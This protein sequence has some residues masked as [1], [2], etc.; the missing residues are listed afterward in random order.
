MAVIYISEADVVRNPTALFE[1]VRAGNEI[2]IEGHDSPIA[3]VSPVQSTEPGV[4]LDY[5]AW[6]IA[7]VD[8]AI[9]DPRERIPSEAVEAY[10]EKRRRA[11]ALKLL[12][13]TG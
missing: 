4:D 6:L 7:K 11:S 8:E 9:A 2:V 5:D 12:G 3:T 10:F 13:M 1:H